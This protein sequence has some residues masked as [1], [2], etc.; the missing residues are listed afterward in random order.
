MNEFLKKLKSG[1][2]KRYDKYDKNRK[3]YNPNQ[4]A[5][6]KYNQKDYKRGNQ[7]KPYEND[8]FMESLTDSMTEIKVSLEKIHS[9]GRLVVE[10]LEKRTEAENRKADTFE[11]ILQMIQPLCKVFE[12]SARK[13]MENIHAEQNV[14]SVR[15]DYKAD[16]RSMLKQRVM[17]MR[18]N[19]SSY[20][21]IARTLQNEN[22][23]TLSGKG[24]WHP[25]TVQRL[26]Q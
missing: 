10:A 21:Q 14:E 19:G 22:I 5:T 24:K 18:E 1:N 12:A 3:P 16:H 17:E 20:S 8:A 13:N 11:Q 26:C 2:D 4:R 9:T 15:E 23:P 7:K 25:Q 6:D